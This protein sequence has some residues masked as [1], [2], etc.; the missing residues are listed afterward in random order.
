MPG[1]GGRVCGCG[2]FLCAISEADAAEDHGDR[3]Q[4]EPAWASHGDTF[5][6]ACLAAALASEGDIDSRWSSPPAGQ[7]C[8]G[9]G[10]GLHAH[11]EDGIT[12][13]H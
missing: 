11:Q 6:I 4:Q 13:L 8:R 9:I 10:D 2:P 5:T 12:V 1:S 3:Q 7:G